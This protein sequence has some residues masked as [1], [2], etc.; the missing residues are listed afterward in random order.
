MTILPGPLSPVDKKK[1][2]SSAFNITDVIVSTE[3]SGKIDTSKWNN[4]ANIVTPEF[5]RARSSMYDSE[6]KK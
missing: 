5:K 1:T 6:H 4:Q 2:T 3:L